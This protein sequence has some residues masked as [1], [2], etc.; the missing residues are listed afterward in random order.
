[1][2]RLAYRL[3]DTLNVVAENL[4]MAL[5]TSPAKVIS[6]VVAWKC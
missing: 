1:M 5:R 3:R 6:S 4:T 2:G